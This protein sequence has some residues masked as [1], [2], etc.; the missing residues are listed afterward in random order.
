MTGRRR[1]ALG[2]WLFVLAGASA[3][4]AASSLP[5][6]S[7]S[8][9]ELPSSP[10]VPTPPPG[11]LGTTDAQLLAALVMAPE[12]DPGGY[13]REAFGYPAAGT[14]SRGCNSRARVLVRDSTTPAQVAYPGCKVLAGRWVDATTGSVYEDPGQV[15]IDHLVPLKEAYRSGASSWSAAQLVTFGNDVERPE[16]LKVI[17][18][19]GNAAKG[20]KD[21]ALWRPPLRS[22]WPAYARAWLVV[23][24]AYALSADPAEA[25]ALRDMLAGA[26]ATTPASSSTSTSPG[27]T[28]IT[29]LPGPTVSTPTS[30]SSCSA[31]RA[32]GKAPLLQGPTRVH[33][34][35]RRGRRRHRLRA[36][37][38]TVVAVCEPATWT[39]CFPSPAVAGGRPVSRQ[40]ASFRSARAR[41]T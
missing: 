1:S 2:A 35:A 36:L 22:S 39:R 37:K 27:P 24:V 19:S 33:P 13:D 16:A 3:A 28:T 17:G 15:S 40:L 4:V 41:A 8:S 32:A 5:T 26:G 23:K 6:G 25:E 10:M 12:V 21:P 9:R 38:S 14:D 20:D 7:T 30:F 29:G 11:P 31:V 34:D 18:G